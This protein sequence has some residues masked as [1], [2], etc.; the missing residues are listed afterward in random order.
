MISIKIQKRLMFIPYI[1]VLVLFFWLYNWFH[2]KWG[3][4][5]AIKGSVI[6]VVAIFAPDIIRDIIIPYLP[7]VNGAIWTFLINYV[8]LLAM[9]F[10]LIRLQVNLLNK[11]EKDTSV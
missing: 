11:Q 5:V 6:S 2:M 4:A 10:G 3:N 7:A 8:S 9:S 1:N